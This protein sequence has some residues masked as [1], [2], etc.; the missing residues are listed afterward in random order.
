M[1]GH[2]KTCKDKGEDEIKNNKLMCL[3]IDNIKPFGL[4]LK[5]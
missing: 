1:S 3:R 4:R 2:A 5:I